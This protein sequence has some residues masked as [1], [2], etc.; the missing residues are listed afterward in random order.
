MISVNKVILA[1]NLARD[2]ELSSIANGSSRTK[3]PVAVERR[4]R[5]GNGENKKETSFFNIITWSRTAE[6][7]AKFLGKGSPVLIEGRISTRTYEDGSGAK[8]YFTE[9]IAGNVTFLPSG[10]RR[11]DRIPPERKAEEQAPADNCQYD[12]DDTEALA[13]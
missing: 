6:N 1:G 9:I 13:F 5:D 4:W 7:C 12:Q 11:E 2:P 3:F 10:K 8:K